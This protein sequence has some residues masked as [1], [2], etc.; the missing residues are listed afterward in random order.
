[1]P[2]GRE[3]PSAVSPTVKLSPVLSCI[4]TCTSRLVASKILI[5][6]H[7]D[8]GHGLLTGWLVQPPAT[9]RRSLSKA[10]HQASLPSRPLDDSLLPIRL[11]LTSDPGSKAFGREPLLPPCS[12]LSGR[13]GRSERL[14]WGL[15][16]SPC[17]QTLPSA[18]NVLRPFFS[19]VLSIMSCSL[20]LSLP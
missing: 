18:W 3:G 15:A 14:E 12:L 8:Q 16:F 2:S 9:V 7:L 6:S 5:L 13:A 19:Q 10:S 4:C 17:A 1:M 11:A 20:G